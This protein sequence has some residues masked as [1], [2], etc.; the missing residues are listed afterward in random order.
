MVNRRWSINIPTAVTVVNRRWSV[1]IPTAV[2]IGQ[3][4]TE[5][6]HSN[7]SYSWSTEDGVS[8]F[9]QQLQLVNRRWN[10][11]IPT[12]VTVGQQKMECQ[13][14]NSSYSWST[15]DG[16]STFQQ[17]LQ[18]VNRRWS[19]NIPTAVTV[20]NRRW[21]V[22]IPTAV[23]I[24]QQKTECHHS[25]SSYSWSTEDGVSTFQQQLQ[26]VNR[27]WNVNIPTAVT[28][29]QQKME[30]Q[31]S[32]SSYSWS[33]EDG[34]STF[35]QQ[36]QLVN[37]RWSVNIRWSDVRTLAADWS[38]WNTFTYY[39][40]FY[41]FYTNV[42]IFLHKLKMMAFWYK[43]EMTIAQYSQ[44]LQEI[45][46]LVH[47]FYFLIT[48]GVSLNTGLDINTGP[49]ARCP[50]WGCRASS[51]HKVSYLTSLV[52]HHSFRSFLYD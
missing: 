4:K 3:Q 51:G 27:R 49:L 30:C 52:G 20:V 18:L 11:T 32:N 13:H 8:T 9:Q 26:L 50:F 17:Q 47:L 37:R 33:T 22:N 39:S 36:L 41:F 1:N 43:K 40:C 7:S 42:F 15:E 12:A 34:V 19:I 21:S 24:G 23:T 25:N 38:K 28:V 46:V 45:L 31:H 2:T 14:S 48:D 29:G 16:M 6:H 10:V 35:Q 44:W 5:C